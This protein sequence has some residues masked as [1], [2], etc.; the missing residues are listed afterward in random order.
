[1]SFTNIPGNNKIKE[2]LIQAFQNNKIAHA[3]LFVGPEG[4]AKLAL[5]LSYAQYI[6]CKKRS[7]EDSCGLCS[8]CLKHKKISHADLHIIFPVIK[9]KAN[10][11]PISQDF[12]QEWIMFINKNPYASLKDWEDEMFK[13]HNINKDPKIYIQEVAKIN[14]IIKLKNYEAENKII[15]IWMPELMD[16]K[17][18]NKL[19]KVL[20]EP[21]QKT[22]IILVSEAPNKL[23]PTIISRLQ[24]NKSNK[25]TEKETIEYF[26]LK[27]IA[28]EKIISIYKRHNGNLGKIINTIE[29]ND[30]IEKNLIIFKQWMRLNYQNNI[31]EINLMTEKLSSEGRREI[32]DVLKYSIRIIRECIIYN[33]AKRE[34]LNVT[35]LEKEFINKFAPFINNKNSILIIEKTDEAIR[36]IERNGNRKII[37]FELSLS[38]IQLLKK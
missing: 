25:L 19:L 28:K 16:K 37:F 11:K 33:Y 21:P 6:H 9:T 1:M 36:N 32:I 3:Q 2:E 26:N 17:T 38:L 22:K 10:D 13:T 8:S 7:Q 24:I 5:A 23:L 15:V 34:C 14:Q 30:S 20:E 18:S 12:L 29:N 31:N 4:N 27:Q 35:P